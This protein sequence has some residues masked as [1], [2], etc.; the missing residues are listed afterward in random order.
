M[1]AF[2][3]QPSA[4]MPSAEDN[5]ALVLASYQAF[6]AGEREAIAGF[7][8]PDAEWIVPEGNAMAIALGQTSGFSG[9]EEIVKYLTENVRG[10]LFSGSKVELLNVVADDRHVVI[11]QLYEATVCNG[12][13]YKVV[14]CFIFEVADARIHQIR[15]YFDTASGF[16][17]IFGDEPPRKLV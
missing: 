13:P 5:K 7:F 2:S 8:A 3:K 14:Q 16:R 1:A 11:E 17:Q 15:A 12:R 6:G 9:R 4:I 10:G